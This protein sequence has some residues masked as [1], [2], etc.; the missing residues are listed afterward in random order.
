MLTGINRAFPYVDADAVEPL[1]EKVSPALFAIAHS[2]NLGGALQA[3]ALLLQL[4]SARA[5]VSDRFYRALYS[6]LLHPGAPRGSSAAAGQLLSLTYRALKDDPRPARAA[7]IVKRLLQVASH[8][9]APFACGSLMLVSELLKHK[10]SHWDA[11]RQPREGED[12]DDVE[13]FVDE[14]DSD[15]ENATAAATKKK[16]TKKGTDQA[17]DDDSDDDAEARAS[18]S[19]SDSEAVRAR[20]ADAASAASAASRRYDMSKR[21]PLYARADASCWWELAT[22][23]RNVHPSVAAMARS[24]LYGTSVEYSGDPLADMTLASFLDKW[25]QKKPKRAK[26]GKSSTMAKRRDEEAYA[27]RAATAPGTAEFAALT[28]DEVDP[29]E[30]FFHRYYATKTEGKKK[31]KKKGDEDKGPEDSDAS[32]DASDDDDEIAERRKKKAAKAGL[33]GFENE[34]DEADSDEDVDLGDLELPDS[35]DE[36]E[37]D[38]EGGG[39]GK[40]SSRRLKSS[41]LDAKEAGFGGADDDAVDEA[42]DD[43]ERKEEA[44]ADADRFNYDALAAAYGAKPGYLLKQMREAREAEEAE[45]EEEEEE[46]DDGVQVWEYEGGEDEEEEDG[47]DVG[48]EE[49]GG[50]EEDEDEDVDGASSSDAS[51][52]ASDSDAS[53]DTSD[54]EPVPTPAAASEPITLTAAVPGAGGKNRGIDMTFASLDDYESMI[55]ADLRENP[56]AQSD[57][58][59]EDGEDGEDDDQ[60]DAAL[61]SDDEVDEKQKTPSPKQPTPRR[62]TR[63]S[64]RARS[65]TGE[66]PAAK[67][68]R[69]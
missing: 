48:I 9:P 57:D 43:E 6:V 24:L 21:D 15:D 58:D 56:P 68:R 7:A 28:E 16:R 17:S 39:G 38:D 2:P 8:A 19:D 36:D 69:R 37:D 12:G 66:T 67:K 47:E 20:R 46:E 1:V 22:L 10:P 59:E 18:E 62:V 65:P 27:E 54:S 35:E 25:L 60:L 23:E 61:A 42:M 32:D 55:E 53:H 41:G 64:M 49:D 45:E 29:S 44:A 33:E 31:K 11:V 4:L 34:D 52:D 51:D 30:V 13:R 40:A 63:S 3:L 50:D 26:G 5:A 14:D